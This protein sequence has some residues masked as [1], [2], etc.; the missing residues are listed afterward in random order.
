MKRYKAGGTNGITS[1]SGK[2]SKSVV[3]LVRTP[4]D[5]VDVIKSISVQPGVEETKPGLA[6]R[7]EEVM[8][9]GDCARYCLGISCQM[10]A[11]ARTVQDTNRW[12]SGLGQ[13]NRHRR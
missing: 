13:W 2:E 8:K 9:Q 6:F 7:N 10:G 1:I 5:A 11:W 4:Y 3:A 12:S